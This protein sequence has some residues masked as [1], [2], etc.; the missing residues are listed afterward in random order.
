[1]NMAQLKFFMEQV[2]L[3]NPDM[4]DIEPTPKRMAALFRR[5][6][7]KSESK[8]TYQDFAKF[9]QPIDLKPYL[10]RIKKKTKLERKHFEMAK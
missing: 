4:N 7:A 10:E 8:L 2:A 1:M 9:L 5:I 6:S 3:A